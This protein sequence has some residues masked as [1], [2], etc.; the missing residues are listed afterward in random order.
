MIKLFAVKTFMD[1]KQMTVAFVHTQCV[2]TYGSI[3]TRDARAKL[4]G[5]GARQG[6]ARVKVCGAKNRIN[7]L[8]S[9]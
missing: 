6:G 5:H 1:C 8:I 3:K 4:L 9:S 2:M 7:Q